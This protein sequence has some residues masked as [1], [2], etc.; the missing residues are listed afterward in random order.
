MGYV[1]S[2]ETDV[3]DRFQLL[4]PMGELGGKP[5]E[6][7]LTPL[8]AYC[9]GTEMQDMQGWISRL[10]AHSEEPI[11][12]LAKPL[13]RCYYA[14]YD[15]D[16]FSW[17]QQIPQ[18]SFTEEQLRRTIQELTDKWVDAKQ[19]LASVEELTRLLTEA[20]LEATWWY[21]PEWTIADLHALSQ[22][23]RLAI[24]RKAEKVRIRFT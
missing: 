6:A 21:D 24:E 11:C 20:N 10:E 23:L 3:G 12:Q 1:A 22:T 15:E 18:K 19:L 4:H 8:Y 13:L 17:L 9:S 7:F 2:V 5:L 16:A 14:G